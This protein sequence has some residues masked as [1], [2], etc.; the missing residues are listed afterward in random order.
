MSRAG[1]LLEK[2]RVFEQDDEEMPD[3]E[4]QDDD[5][6]DNDGEDEDDENPFS[7]ENRNPDGSMKSDGQDVINDKKRPRKK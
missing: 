4:E 2:L 1:A 7:K 5:D 3:T 6:E